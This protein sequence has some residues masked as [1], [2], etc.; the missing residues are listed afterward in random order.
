MLVADRSRRLESRLTEFYLQ[1]VERVFHYDWVRIF[2]FSGLKGFRHH[3]RD[4]DSKRLPVVIRAHTI[5]ATLVR[6]TNSLLGVRR[7]SN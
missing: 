2:V 1:Y 3:R 5:R 7:W 4:D 6:D